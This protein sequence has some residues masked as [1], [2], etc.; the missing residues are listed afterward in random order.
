[1]HVAIGAAAIP[2]TSTDPEVVIAAARQA[3]EMAKQ[4]RAPYFFFT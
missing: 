1:V 3:S 4:N 2:E